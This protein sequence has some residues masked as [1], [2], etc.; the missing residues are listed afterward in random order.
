ME[1]N[2]ISLTFYFF[3]SVWILR[4]QLCNGTQY[5]V[6]TVY[7]R[8]LIYVL[9]FQLFVIYDQMPISVTCETAN[10]DNPKICWIEMWLSCV[11][12]QMFN[13]QKNKR[14]RQCLTWPQPFY[15]WFSFF[16]CFSYETLLFYVNLR[17]VYR[18]LHQHFH[19]NLN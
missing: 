15:V 17:S 2:P 9:L 1:E 16:L 10:T 7:N 8:H 19:A 14:S 12:E 11:C 6:F 13:L 4:R 18:T 5:L 3:Q